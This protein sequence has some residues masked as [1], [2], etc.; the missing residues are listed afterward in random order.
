MPLSYSQL[1]SYRRCPKQYEYATIKKIPR[2]ISAGE[3][4]GSSIHNTLR[5]FGELEREHAK[6]LDPKKQ[7]TLFIDEHPSDVLLPLEYPTLLAWWKECFIAEGYESITDK[8]Q[9]FARGE[10]LLQR[11]FEW[12]KEKKRT[13]IAIETG[14]R[15]QIASSENTTIAGRFDRIEQSP[16]GLHIIDYKTSAIC[17]QEAADADL[18]L[19]IYWLAAAQQYPN[20]PIE[21][22]SLLFLDEEGCTERITS[23]SLAEQQRALEEISLLNKGIQSEDFHATPSKEKCQRCPYRN[24]CPQSDTSSS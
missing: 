1:S 7:L 2:Y 14:F 15:L 13:V 9:A 5:R 21:S 18:Q 10:I 3:S 23:R 19:S 16:N 6:T 17:T 24:I 20:I 4:F 11:F 8:N 22:L 12:W